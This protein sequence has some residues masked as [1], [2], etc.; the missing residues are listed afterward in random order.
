MILRI[1]ENQFLSSM[2]FALIFHALSLL[3]PQPI[4]NPDYAHAP[5]YVFSKELNKYMGLKQLYMTIK[6][7]GLL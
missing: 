2:T 4:K 1:T 3:Y 7:L 6:G 5:A